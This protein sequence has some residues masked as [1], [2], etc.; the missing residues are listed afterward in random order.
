M[1]PITRVV[2]RRWKRSPRSVIAFMV[3]EVNPRN[4]Y[5]DSFEH[6]GQHA[7]AD[8]EGLLSITALATP[9]EYAAL[10]RELERAPY[11]YNIKPISRKNQ[12]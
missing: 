6:V 10:K 9:D 7:E 3:D 2:F 12:K 5:V 1:N 11:H 8:Y 4:G